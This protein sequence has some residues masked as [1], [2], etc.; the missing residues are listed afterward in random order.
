MRSASASRRSRSADSRRRARAAARPARRG[1]SA[2]TAT[3][4]ASGSAPTMPAHEEVA[5]HVVGLVAVDRRCRAAARPD[6]RALVRVAAPR[7]PRA[8]SR[9]PGGRRAR[10]IDVAVGGGDRQL[11]ADRR[12]ALRDAAAAPRRRRARRRP[13]PRRRRRRRGTAPPRRR[14]C[15]RWRGRRGRGT[16]GARVSASAASARSVGN[17]YG[18]ASRIAPTAPVEVR[19]CPASAPR[20]RR[21]PRP[22]G[23]ERSCARPPP[24]A[25][26]H[27]ATRG[28]VLD[29]APARRSRRRRRSRPARRAR[30]PRARPRASPPAPPGARR[31]R[32]RRRGRRRAPSSAARAS[33]PASIAADARVRDRSRGRMPM[34]TPMPAPRYSRRDERLR[35]RSTPPRSGADGCSRVFGPTGVGKTDVALALADRLR[36][37]GRGPGRRLRRRAAGLR[38]PRDRSPASPTP[39]ER[40]RLEH[41]LVSLPAGRRR[42][43]APAQYAELAHAEID[44]L[45]A[46]GRRPIV[47]GGTGLYLRA[48]LAELDLR[49]RAGRRRARALG[50]A[51]LAQRRRRR[52]CTREL[53]R[54]APW[55]AAGIDP[56]DRHRIVRALELLDAGELEPPDGARPQLWTTDTRH[57][58]LLVGARRWTATRSTRGSTRASTRWSPPARSTRSAPRT[59]P[60]PRRPRA[61]RSASTSC[62]PATSRR[63]SA[64]RAATPS[65]SSRGCASCPASQLVDVTGRDA[66]RRRRRDPGDAPARVVGSAPCASR[67][68]RR[69]ATTT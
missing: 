46:R 18:S 50:R 33:V 69:W 58:T 41:R 56:T 32:T 29:L 39:A 14:A 26:A 42:R 10:A 5:L 28:A 54:R 19:A 63:C 8:A 57:P 3:C 11:G 27:T 4:P 38:G 60:A 66:G 59:P 51:Q 24:S 53:A 9:A 64:A 43:S 6:E 44:A 15:A 12:G 52:R 49:P 16:R 61:R 67:S 62:S 45:L 13:R 31:R 30:A 55:A 35:A 25:A 20:P 40:A 17:V 37:R 22:C 2:P 7:S 36:A 34:R 1:P 48:A 47:V 68:G 21:A 23:V 65:A